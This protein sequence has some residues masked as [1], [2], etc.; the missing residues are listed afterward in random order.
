MHCF[1]YFALLFILPDNKNAHPNLNGLAG[2][3]GSLRRA[4]GASRCGLCGDCKYVSPQ[5]SILGKQGLKSS[6]PGPEQTVAEFKL[7]RENAVTE[8]STKIVVWIDQYPKVTLCD[9]AKYCDACN[10][11]CSF[12]L[13]D[14]LETKVVRCVKQDMRAGFRFC[15]GCLGHDKRKSEECAPAKNSKLIPRVQSEENISQ[16]LN[17]QEQMKECPDAETLSGRTTCH[18]LE[19]WTTKASATCSAS[20]LVAKCTN[21]GE[22]RTSLWGRDIEEENPEAEMHRDKRIRLGERINGSLPTTPD[23]KNINCSET[24][25][26]SFTDKERMCCSMS[27]Y[28]QPCLEP[29]FGSCNSF[30]SAVKENGVHKKPC[31]QISEPSKTDAAQMVSEVF[32]KG[33]EVDTD[34]LESFTCQRVRAYFRKL[35]F[36]CARTYMPWPF[37]NSGC[38]LTANASITACPADS[39]PINQSGT[40]SSQTRAPTDPSSDA[41]NQASHQSSEEKQEEN[42]ESI[43]N[44][45]NRKRHGCMFSCS[46]DSTEAEKSLPSK[47][48]GTAVFTTP[49][50]CGSEP[51]TATVSASSTPVNE[52]ETNSSLATPSPSALGLIDWEM[53]TTLSPTSSPFTHVGF[54]SLSTTPSSFLLKKSRGVELADAHSTSASPSSPK[55]MLDPVEKLKTFQASCHSAPLHN[56]DSSHSCESSLILLQ[57]EQE[58]DENVFSDRSPPKLESYYNTSPVNH[59]YNDPTEHW[60]ETNSNEFMLLPVLSPI[61]S[62]QRYSRTSSSPQIQGCLEEELV[63][64]DLGKHKMLPE[65]HMPQITNGSRQSCNGDVDHQQR[66]ECCNEE[67]DGILSGFKTLSTPSNVGDM[68]DSNEEESQ[69]ETDYEDD[70]EQGNSSSEQVPLNPKVKTTLTSA[71]LTEPHSSPSSDEDDGGGCNNEGQPRFSAEELSSLSEIAG[72]EGDPAE[73]AGD[74]QPGVLDEFTAYE[75]D[76]LLVDVIQ[77]DTELFEN[78]PEKSLLKLGP[79]RVSEARPAGAEKT[80]TPRID[81]ASLEFERK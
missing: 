33:T 68:N 54:S 16:S 26:T 48:S 62:P 59:E 75:Q 38:T 23:L 25:K 32:S 34:D 71:V 35:K 78:L 57:D 65:R 49:S 66:R 61:P 64:K 51:H 52:A 74:T 79:V 56:S 41:P 63:N 39:S 17:D 53:T 60:V 58:S 42:G 19:G 29:T 24:A 72:H 8:A 77:D 5:Q 76:I 11:N 28:R 40:L 55:F 43:L 46:P 70:G 27:D 2:S 30:G 4:V 47:L 80:L 18:F 9:V 6:S 31:S 15:P 50:Q 21:K 10:H 67:V 13:P 22:Y 37:S 7:K 45:R 14:I 1:F 3:E 20:F 69:D 81:G 44:E 12:V 36:S 73:A